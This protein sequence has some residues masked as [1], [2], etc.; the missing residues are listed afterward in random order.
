MSSFPMIIVISRK[1]MTSIGLIIYTEAKQ[2]MYS[3]S[4]ELIFMIIFFFIFSYTFQVS[5]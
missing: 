5:K 2:E 4:K 1:S 3:K